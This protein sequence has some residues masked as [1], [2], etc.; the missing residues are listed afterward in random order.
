[1]YKQKE[2]ACVYEYERLG[3]DRACTVLSANHV[4]RNSRYNLPI[5]SRKVKNRSCEFFLIENCAF[6]EDFQ[7]YIKINVFFLACCS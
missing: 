5:T 4:P 1:M 6:F 3:T 7:S 2:N